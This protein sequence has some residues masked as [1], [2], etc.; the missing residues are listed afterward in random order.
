MLLV[1]PL[2]AFCVAWDSFKLVDIQSM[3]SLQATYNCLFFFWQYI[4]SKQGAAINSLKLVFF[5]F[6]P[7]YLTLC[8]LL[9]VLHWAKLSW[10]PPK[11]S[12]DT[13]EITALLHYYLASSFC[14]AYSI[15]DLRIFAGRHLRNHIFV[16]FF[17][18]DFFARGTNSICLCR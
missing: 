4:Y 14:H 5:F 17:F 10:L 18:F 13:L 1:S 12:L 6:S 15:V 9:L 16:D 11:E 3:S 8:Q 2:T 7:E